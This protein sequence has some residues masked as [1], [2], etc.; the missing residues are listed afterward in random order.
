MLTAIL[1]VE[2]D[3]NA[4]STLGEKIAA[5]EAVSEVYSVTGQWDFV[6]MVRV[7]RHEQLS[8]VLAGPV[9]SLEGVTRQQTM[10]AFAAISTADLDEVFGGDEG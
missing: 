3:R 8:E 2:A 7:P 5:I 6:A 1:L 4:L 10:V 9:A